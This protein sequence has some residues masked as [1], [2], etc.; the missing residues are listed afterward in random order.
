MFVYAIL[1]LTA[2]KRGWTSLKVL[3]DNQ[4][5]KALMEN[6]LSSARS[7]HIGV[8]FH[9]I[10]NLFRTRIISVGYIASA[11]QH[12]DNLTKVLSRVNFQYHRLRLTNLLK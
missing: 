11:E 5:T 1:P 3:E 4:G 12:T 10:R 8:H 2:P 7:K 9:F 6:S